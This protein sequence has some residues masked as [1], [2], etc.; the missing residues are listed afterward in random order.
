MQNKVNQK[1]EMEYTY[2]HYYFKLGVKNVFLARQA[3][4]KILKEGD[5]IELAIYFTKGGVEHFDKYRPKEGEEIKPIETEEFK[6]TV[7]DFKQ[8][9]MFVDAVRKEYHISIFWLFNE[10]QIY[11]CQA[12]DNQIF[13]GTLKSD[14]TEDRE[15]QRYQNPKSA[16]VKIKHIFKQYD[17]ICP[18]PEFFATTHAS[19]EYNRKTIVPFEKDSIK[20][21]CEHLISGQGKMLINKN[22]RLDFLSPLQFETLIFLIFYNKHEAIFCST[23][24]G[25]STKDIDLIIEIP[26]NIR[27]ILNTQPCIGKLKFQIKMYDYFKNK[28]SKFSQEDVYLIH[29]GEKQEGKILGRSWIDEEISKSERLNYWLNRSLNYFFEIK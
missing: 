28:N 1:K 9:G 26:E 2:K 19:Q 3:T 6:I 7:D 27:L 23:Y 11:A 25:G 17:E 13:D 10:Q 29:L 16:K 5:E 15:K 20:R 18:I 12:I 24:R 21:V 4:D 14:D 8:V 22:E